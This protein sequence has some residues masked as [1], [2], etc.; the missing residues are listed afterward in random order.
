MS[1][2]MIVSPGMSLVV[3]A[4][5]VASGICFLLFNS[6]RKGK[7]G[8]SK[9][10]GKQIPVD[11]N[12]CAC[13]LKPFYV[14]RGVRCNDC[15]ARSCRKGCSRWDTS[16]NAWHCLFCLQQRYWLNKTA[17]SGGPI[18]EQDLYR[19]FDTAKSRVYVAGVEHAAAC[20]GLASA[21]AKEETNAMETVQDF[22]EK[23]AEGLIGKVN[24]APID[25]L[26]AL[27]A[28]KANSRDSVTMA[29]TALRD[30]VERA[31]E[32]A[33]KL[34]GLTGSSETGRSR[35]EGNIA[36]HSYEDL[37]ATAILNK[38]IEKFQKE[39]VDGN[40]NVLHGKSMSASELENETELDQG[41]EEG[42]PLPRDD[43]SS[44][45]G[46]SCS[47]H[48]RNQP[49]PLSMT[50]EEQI[51]EV[52]TTY[53][54]DEDPKDNDV[55]AVRSAHRVPFPEL[56]M[57]IIDPS[58]ESSEDSQDEPDT[59]TTP[60]RIA[61][62]SPVESWE[63]N[64]LFQKKRIQT[65][66]D[67]VAMLVPNSSADFKAMIGD[68]DAEDTSDLSECSSTQSDEEIEKELLE[69]INNV[70]PR[71]P[72]ERLLENGLTE[73]LEN[74]N[75]LWTDSFTFTNTR[76]ERNRVETRKEDFQGSRK[77]EQVTAKQ[78][79]RSNTFD[80]R[81]EMDKFEKTDGEL[82]PKQISVIDD[83]TEKIEIEGES[84]NKENVNVENSRNADHPVE[85]TVFVETNSDE[86]TERSRVSLP[87]E[88][89]IALPKT[90][91]STPRKTSVAEISI[92]GANDAI[93]L[94]LT[95]ERVLNS[96]EHAKQK[97][98]GVNDVA[99][100][101]FAKINLDQRR[102]DF[103]AEDIQQES[104][105]TE[106]YDI[107]IQRHL[108]SLTKIEN[109][110]IDDESE[111]RC[112]TSENGLSETKE[113][114]RK[115]VAAAHAE[116]ASQSSPRNK[117]SEEDVRLATPP[118]PGTIAEREHKKWENAPPI[119]NNPYSEENI[120]K[121]LWERQYTR[122]SSDIPGIHAE[123][124][125]SN[126]TDLE[127]VLTPHQ[128]DIKRF[129]RDYYIN[130]SKAS[131]IEKG[132]RS[133]ASTSSRPSSSLSQ[134]SSSTGADQEQQEDVSYKETEFL[135][136]RSND[137]KSKV[138]KWQNNNNNNNINMN[139]LETRYQPLIRHGEGD[140]EKNN[141][142]D[143]WEDQRIEEILETERKNSK[144][145]MNAKLNSQ[146]NYDNPIIE[147]TK[148]NSEENQRK[149]KRI[150]LKAYG[151]DNSF[152]S[153]DNKT[154][155]TSTPRVVNKLDLKSFGY[156]D[157]IRRTQSNVHLNSTVN[158]KDCKP[159]IV[160][161]T[162]KSNLTRRKGYDRDAIETR[163]SVDD[164]VTQ[165]TETLN[166]LFESKSYNDFG[167]KSA[168]S[169]PNL[170]RYY[171]NA[172][173][174]QEGEQ[175]EEYSR[176]SYDSQSEVIK[177]DSVRNIAN[178]Y[179]IE[180]CNA[181]TIDSSVNESENDTD[182]SCDK[183]QTKRSMDSIEKKMFNDAGFDKVLPMP[184]VRRLA[185]AFNKQPVPGSVAVSKTVKPNNANK[186]RSSTPEVQIVETPRQMHSLT[187][188]SLS[189]QFREGLRQIPTKITSPPASH[190]T[191][192]QFN[193]PENQTEVILGKN[194][195]D[196]TCTDKGVIFPGKLKS[197][198]IFWEQMQRK[199]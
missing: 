54:S 103:H 196:D 83:D 128:P 111:I 79:E 50:I 22:V 161:V 57:D 64:W 193:I 73:C 117:K 72:K 56:G 195:A 96:L 66:A 131:S 98:L 112:A 179:S 10:D 125:K 146:E 162:N 172:D 18:N 61:L 71:S 133:A 90:P 198:I 36:E 65:Q 97:L 95:E 141:C 63:E 181:K 85:Q 101:T 11:E 92:G 163:I 31:V 74:S 84:R 52:T 148:S 69:A 82:I 124:P 113:R 58:Q 88:N 47:R 180:K 178:S 187:A 171:S 192:E 122:R 167:L 185:Q 8:D 41:V 157:G 134:R 24:D 27:P 155:K 126:G 23:I 168:K 199:S 87:E 158:E 45:Y 183:E 176:H 184:S 33:R 186:D 173:S 34:P 116:S 21:S 107:A 99:V 9:A 39:Q 120:Q 160:R 17:T 86:P 37:L 49:E 166:N 165:S 105:Y 38:V 151:F 2:K 154:S 102:D 48:V 76:I 140:A 142:S 42:E 67:P 121:R 156:D 138:A 118:R 190:V 59:S 77:I 143:S 152:R 153:N 94:N 4:V 53:T 104:E 55:L 194:D 144:N 30:V 119:E 93:E 12:R 5:G 51:E 81:K 40:S 7:S 1:G 182:N 150:D 191:M 169:V 135:L 110:G 6:I 25:R 106:H 62:V 109:G 91:T 75:D 159:R 68:K 149:I 130:E 147:T 43:S 137:V 14:G 188:R 20:S 19:Y 78:V 114:C 28:Y 175:V 3:A 170:P 15:G 70:V 89:D 164:N 44:D 174:D 108:D 189:K 26:Y 46:A 132:R 197:N 129:G 16:D 115:A 177:N 80:T 127:V 145:E 136:N 32:E 35:E 123:L 13:C 60:T 29:H 139:N 100:G